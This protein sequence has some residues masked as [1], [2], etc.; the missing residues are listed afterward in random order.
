VRWYCEEACSSSFLLIGVVLRGGP[1]NT[2][3][4]RSLTYAPGVSVFPAR[5]DFSL[6]GFMSMWMVAPRV[7]SATVYWTLVL[8][9]HFNY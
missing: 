1:K 9:D 8:L 3:D 2:L 4:V 7:S 5:S 6:G